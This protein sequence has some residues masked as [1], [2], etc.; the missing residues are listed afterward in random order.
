MIKSFENS[1]NG[2]KFASLLMQFCSDVNRSFFK[3][4][5]ETNDNKPPM[6]LY[7]AHLG[8]LFF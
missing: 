3:I 8:G 1:D 5:L 2:V 7:D 6:P 4:V